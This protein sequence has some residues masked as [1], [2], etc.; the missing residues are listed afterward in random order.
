MAYNLIFVAK[1]QIISEIIYNQPQF[2]TLFNKE[3]LNQLSRAHKC[4]H[5][6]NDR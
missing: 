3:L 2:Y 1:V 5:D 6:S 4:T